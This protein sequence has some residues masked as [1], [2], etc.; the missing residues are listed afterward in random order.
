MVRKASATT[1]EF[2]SDA[3]EIRRGVLARGRAQLGR[4]LASGSDSN[5]EPE[6]RYVRVG[7]LVDQG[8][9]VPCSASLSGA[10]ADGHDSIAH[11]SGGRNERLPQCYSRLASSWHIGS[12][13]DR[14]RCCGRV[15]GGVRCRRWRCC[16]HAASRPALI[17]KVAGAWTPSRSAPGSS[18]AMHCPPGSGG[19]KNETP[20]GGLRLQGRPHTKAPVAQLDVLVGEYTPSGRCRVSP[21][22]ALGS[23]TK[24][25][26]KEQS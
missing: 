12:R 4:Q 14:T 20:F 24:S 9:R 8:R 15:S 21:P 18:A 10:E 7:S 17:G 6:D 19:R 16:D 1:L 26:G 23:G 3:V 5:I 22:P 11:R 13:D 25:I 2:A